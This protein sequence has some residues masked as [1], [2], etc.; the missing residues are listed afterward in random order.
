MPALV[1]AKF[2]GNHESMRPGV[3]AGGKN[4]PCF[5][6]IAAV[7]FNVEIKPASFSRNACE[8]F[9]EY[10][11][12]QRSETLDIAPGCVLQGDGHEVQGRIDAV[13]ELAT[14]LLVNAEDDAMGRRIDKPRRQDIANAASQYKIIVPLA[15]A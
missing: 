12:S 9:A 2:L 10:A 6:R 14:D 4:R 8:G 15:L 7:I 11:G 13:G 3:V 1:L 5:V